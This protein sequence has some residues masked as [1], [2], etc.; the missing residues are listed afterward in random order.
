MKKTPSKSKKEK[1]S[2]ICPLLFILSIYELESK[3]KWSH[4][5]YTED[6]HDIFVHDLNYRREQGY[7]VD[8]SYGN[9]EMWSCKKHTFDYYA[10]R[11]PCGCKKSSLGCYC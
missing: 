4:T 10:D 11:Y 2:R 3:G 8:Q 7:I 5:V 1:S 9:L 6:Q